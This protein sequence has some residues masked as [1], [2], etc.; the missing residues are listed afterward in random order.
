MF[1]LDTING[2]FGDA[3]TVADGR[4]TVSR[5]EVLAGPPMDQLVRAAVFADG[6][7][8]IGAEENPCPGCNPSRLSRG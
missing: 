3:V 8:A 4:V 5:P 1:D 7:V 2:L 6:F